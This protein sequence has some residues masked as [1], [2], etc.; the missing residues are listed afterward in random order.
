M[1]NCILYFFSYC[2]FNFGFR[3]ENSIIKTYSVSHYLYKGCI[4]LKIISKCDDMESYN[5]KI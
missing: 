2:K 3:T 5:K 1:S 4:Y